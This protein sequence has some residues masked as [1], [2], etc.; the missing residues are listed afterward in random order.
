MYQPKRTCGAAFRDSVKNLY[1]LLEDD[2]ELWRL[3]EWMVFSHWK[4]TDSARTIMSSDAI[5]AYVGREVQQSRNFSLRRL[6]E[7]FSER[8]FS[9]TAGDF[10]TGRSSVL[11]TPLPDELLSLIKSHLQRAT[12]PT[13]R[14]VYFA[15]GKAFTRASYAAEQRSLRDEALRATEAAYSQGKESGAGTSAGK[16]IDAI[17]EMS[18]AGCPLAYDLLTYL[19]SLPSHRFNKIK[20]NL[21]AAHRKADEIGTD[22]ER[23]HQILRAIEDIAQPF[24]RPT[25]ADLIIGAKGKEPA[26]APRSVRIFS[27]NESIL[28]LQSGVRDVLTQGW[29][30]VDLRAAQ[31]A[32][33]S[34]VWDVP[35]LRTY[36]SIC[37]SEGG[38]VWEELLNW[39][40]LSSNG[41]NKSKL[42][43]M[44]Y[45]LVFGMGLRR[46]KIQAETF[47]PQM[48]D[49]WGRF[50]RQYLMA[51]LLKARSKEFNRLRFK[52]H[53]LDAFGNRLDIRNLA[54]SDERYQPDT[55][56][57]VM[58]LV[59]QSYELLL[60]EPIIRHANATK[61]ATNGFVIMG[62]LY[63]GC[64]LE[65]P[66]KRTVQRWRNR[67]DAEI[68]QQAQKLGIPTHLEWE[69]F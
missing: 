43:D 29:I 8:A 57:S 38:S 15:T 26:Y 35:I 33:I 59:A 3:L 54:R 68:G 9:V 63:D 47:F 18:Q 41:E 40:G 58:S 66:D 28:R 25:E 17:W 27:I 20:T 19:N 51:D 55:A 64:W 13:E 60:L 31:L 2:Y 46:M 6:L 61:D 50:K 30:K 52:G 36:L 62:W 22:P 4:D 49:P 53:A 34:Q 65:F 14:R 12:A 1:P 45:S 24:Y 7:R 32:I 67:L 42:K 16:Q 44:V 10:R 21:D 48:S 37:I 11:L 5:R 69:G 56:S 39:M 23:Q